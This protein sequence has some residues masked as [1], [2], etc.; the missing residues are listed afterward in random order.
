MAYAT[1]D[2]GSE[3][4]IGRASR[5]GS[6]VSCSSSLRMALPIANRFS[7]SVTLVTVRAYVAYRVN[8]AARNAGA[9]RIR[10]ASGMRCGG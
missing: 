7:N 3:A 10:T 5:L 6:S 9:A 8:R 2:S 4:K 1:D